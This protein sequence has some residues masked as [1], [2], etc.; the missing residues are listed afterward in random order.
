M[1]ALSIFF[2]SFL[3]VSGR[4]VVS[5][6]GAY[7]PSAVWAKVTQPRSFL[8]EM[9]WGLSVSM[10]IFAVM[11]LAASSACVASA[12]VT[13]GS[14]AVTGTASSSRDG[15]S[16]SPSTATAW[17]MG[18]EASA[19]RPSLLGES[20]KVT[21]LGRRDRGIDRVLGEQAKPTGDPL[22]QACPRRT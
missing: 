21:S 9:D 18:W 13:A 3:M 5:M 1:G 10:L 8:A 22:G 12:V 2:A 14:M 17:A 11:R 16:S 19:R 6:E 15:A 20:L 7:P 4:A